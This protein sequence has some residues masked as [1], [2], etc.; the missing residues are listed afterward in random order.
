M[1][2]MNNTDNNASLDLL[3]DIIV[4]Q[5]VE[6]FPPATGWIA[7]ILLLASYGFY[8]YIKRRAHYQANLYRRQALTEWETI[9]NS[10]TLLE[11]SQSML[12]LIKRVALQ[13]FGRERVATLSGDA[14][15]DFVEQYS[16]ATIDAP[17]RKLSQEL[18]YTQE[19]AITKEQSDALATVTK[20]WIE[21]HQKEQGEQDD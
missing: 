8:W 10:E 3:Q 14:W 19:T 5:G 1:Q 17:L 16:D 13:H 4:P 15:W 11:Q 12:L 21:T 18:L 2:D 6:Y 20:I 9:Q 7:V